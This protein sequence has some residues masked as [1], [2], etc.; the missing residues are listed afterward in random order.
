MH[1]IDGNKTA[2]AFLCVCVCVCVFASL[3]PEPTASRVGAHA[4]AYTLCSLSR[5][6]HA[7]DDDGADDAD[8]DGD[9]GDGDHQS[10]SV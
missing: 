1:K 3:F 2:A 9:G 5:Y 7:D 6:L 10:C 4:D 8:D